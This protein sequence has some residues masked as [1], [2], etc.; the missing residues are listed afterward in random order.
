MSNGKVFQY[1]EPDFFHLERNLKHET[2]MYFN[3]GEQKM[4]LG[5]VMEL[6]HKGEVRARYLVTKK[7]PR[8]FSENLSYKY[9]LTK[10][11]NG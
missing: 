4:E 9:I 8:K 5:D 11:E 3:E 6:T 1:E 7:E 10:I 2:L